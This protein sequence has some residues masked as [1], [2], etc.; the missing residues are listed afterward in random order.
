M[1]TDIISA[2]HSRPD[3]QPSSHTHTQPVH[4]TYTTHSESYS[5]RFNTLQHNGQQGS[6]TVTNYSQFSISPMQL[7]QND[8]YIRHMSVSQMATTKYSN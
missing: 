6:H 1:P 4:M 8:A 2:V 7:I 5:F 3:Q